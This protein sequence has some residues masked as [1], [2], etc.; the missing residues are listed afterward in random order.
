[1]MAVVDMAVGKLTLRLERNKCESLRE[2]KSK[3]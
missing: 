2:G 3:M 1:M